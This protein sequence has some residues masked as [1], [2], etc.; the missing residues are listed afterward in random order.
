[1]SRLRLRQGLRRSAD[2]RLLSRPGRLLDRVRARLHRCW[3]D[4]CQ[5]GRCADSGQRG[6]QHQLVHFKR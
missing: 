4:L 5:D 1:L 3:G 2:G 6:E